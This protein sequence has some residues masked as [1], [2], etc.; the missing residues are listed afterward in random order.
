[1]R[2]AVID[3][4]APL[5]NRAFGSAINFLSSLDCSAAFA[6]RHGPGPTP[7]AA[8]PFRLKP[9]LMAVR[10]RT[11]P[12]CAAAASPDTEKLGSCE[13]AVCIK[14]FCSRRFHRNSADCHG[15]RAVLFHK[16]NSSHNKLGIPVLWQIVLFRKSFRIIQLIAFMVSF[17][18][19][20]LFVRHSLASGATVAK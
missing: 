5:D 17:P 3:A 11:Q 15:K 16:F 14:N 6:A 13:A 19:Q 8:K 9:P 18:D 7:T 12:P 4:A 2:A 10:L 20:G 1:M